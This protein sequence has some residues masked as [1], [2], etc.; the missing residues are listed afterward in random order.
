MTPLAL[1]A[2]A[3]GG[4]AVVVGAASAVGSRGAP[5]PRTPTPSFGGIDF[6]KLSAA[7]DATAAK[8]KADRD[9]RTADANAKLDDWGKAVDNYTGTTLGSWDAGVAKLAL[10]IEGAVVRWVQGDWNSDDQKAR[11]LSAVKRALDAGIVPRS[12]DSDID[13]AKTYADAV[14]DEIN[15]GTSVMGQPW[16]TIVDDYRTALLAAAAKNDARVLS[17]AIRTSG[18]FSQEFGAPFLC[19][20]LAGITGKSNPTWTYTAG[21]GKD[22]PLADLVAAVAVARY[23]MPLAQALSIAYKA[24]VSV[25]NDHPTICSGRGYKGDPDTWDYDMG[26]WLYVLRAWIDLTP[27]G[28]HKRWGIP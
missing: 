24:I 9:K 14:E 28:L 6:D 23:G 10:S 3:I 12:F 20:A 8:D 13:F 4:T 2:I 7:M 19:G 5:T 22:Y 1:A 18:Y 11:A 27:P 26:P 17:A 15:K 16:Q 25:A 21:Q